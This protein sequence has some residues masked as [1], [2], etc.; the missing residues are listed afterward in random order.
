[1]TDTIP[2]AP[3]RAASEDISEQS[4]SHT[5]NGGISHGAA[6]AITERLSEMPDLPLPSSMYQGGR[7][8]PPTETVLCY[9]QQLL[10]KDPAAFLAR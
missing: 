2:T 3:A 6:V 7:T 1:M 9:L 4:Y 8:A 10:Q 5:S